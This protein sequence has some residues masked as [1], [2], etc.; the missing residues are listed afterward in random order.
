MWRSW[1]CGEAAARPLSYT[2]GQHAFLR[3]VHDDRAAD[4]P[5]L[6]TVDALGLAPQQ[7]HPAILRAPITSR[8]QP[9]AEHSSLMQ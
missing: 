6:M 7:V 1:G 3:H 2:T 4:D 8:Y 9:P 5:G